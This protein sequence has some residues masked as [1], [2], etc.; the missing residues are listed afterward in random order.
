MTRPTRVAI[1]TPPSDMRVIP[2]LSSRV[3]QLVLS[4]EFQYL[5]RIQPNQ[6]MMYNEHALSRAAAGA[7]KP[8]LTFS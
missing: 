3:G 2:S 4:E 1:K 7:G 8:Q 5:E 6:S